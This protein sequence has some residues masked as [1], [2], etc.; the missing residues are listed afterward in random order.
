M[1]GIAAGFE[2]QAQLSPGDTDW[3]SFLNVNEDWI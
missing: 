3:S 1:I 2:A